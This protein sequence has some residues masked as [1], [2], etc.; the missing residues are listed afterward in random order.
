MR[1]SVSIMGLRAEVALH[2]RAHLFRREFHWLQNLEEFK[3]APDVERQQ[4]VFN[5]Q[6]LRQLTK[7]RAGAKTVFQPEQAPADHVP[8]RR[9]TRSRE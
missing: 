5:L 4:V 2:L 3:Q 6:L 8:D 9:Q 7:E 1:E